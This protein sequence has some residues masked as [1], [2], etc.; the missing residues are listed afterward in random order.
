MGAHLE[1]GL[2]TVP[3]LDKGSGEDPHEP[4][5]THQLH[6]E[7]LQHAVDGTV[8]L[9]PAPV[10]LVV[11]HLG[12]ITQRRPSGFPQSAAF[13]DQRRA[14]S[15]PSLDAGQP[16]PLQALDSRPVGDDDHDLCR[17]GRPPG[18]FHQGLEVGAW[19]DG[20]ALVHSRGCRADGV[21]RV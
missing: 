18:V 10:Q 7:L 9:R 13:S 2:P 3:F 6:P 5:Q 20:D 15:Y 4:G 21:N 19:S 8:E 1:R 12:A 11:H 16:R 17:A 14:R